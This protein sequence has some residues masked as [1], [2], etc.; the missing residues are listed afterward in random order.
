MQ[1]NEDAR[2]RQ[3]NQWYRF[4]LARAMEGVLESANSGAGGVRVNRQ[5]VGM[6]DAKRQWRALIAQANKSGQHSVRKKKLGTG[7]GKLR[8]T[9]TN[10]EVIVGFS[11][12]VAKRVFPILFKQAFQADRADMENYLEKRLRKAL[13]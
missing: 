1:K 4:G 6:L 2:F 7:Y 10:P 8:G 5:S 3:A 11:G 9:P 12:R 13:R